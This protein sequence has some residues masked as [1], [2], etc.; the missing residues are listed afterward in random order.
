MAVFGLPHALFGNHW[1]TDAR[2]YFGLLTAAALGYAVSLLRKD[3][4][5]VRAVQM[6][7]VLPLCALTLAT[8]GDDIPVLGL[9]LLSMTLLW[10]GRFGWA[11][12]AI[13]A[14]AAMKLFAWPVLVVLAFFAWRKAFWVPAIAI[15]AL[16][17][18]P[19]IILD[20]AAV[21]ENV[22]AFPTGHGLVTSPAASPLVGYLLAQHVAGG[23]TLALALLGL[24]ATAIGVYLL[25]RRPRDV[26]AVANV[27]AIGLLV[28]ILLIPATRFGYLL[29]PVAFAFWAPCLKDGLRQPEPEVSRGQTNGDTRQ[30]VQQ[31]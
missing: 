27:C 2:I 4:R 26:A 18:L 12:V 20:A 8:G 31:G 17:L 9:C 15:P 24:A 25:L 7:T 19:S 13:G 6:A 1:W 28:A 11:G 23:R 30:S 14:A 29:Y 3:G 10:R 22:I 21:A 5:L 16:V